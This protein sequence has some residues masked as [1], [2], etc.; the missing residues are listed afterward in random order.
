[1][2]QQ[3]ASPKMDVVITLCDRAANE[4]CP[5]WQGHPVASHWSIP[6][7]SQQGQRSSGPDAAF[8]R[9][10]SDLSNRIARFNALDIKHLSRQD[11]QSEIDRIALTI[12]EGFIT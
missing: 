5:V 2:F 6:D 10:Y 3:T 1:M 4:E 11:L 7:P 12:Q 8:E 9:M